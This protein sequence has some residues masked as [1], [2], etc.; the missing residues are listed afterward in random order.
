MP[1][2]SVAPRCKRRTAAEAMASHALDF[3]RP[4]T[5]TKEREHQQPPLLARLLSSSD[6]LRSRQ[7]IAL[8]QNEGPHHQKQQCLLSTA[9]ILSALN[10]SAMQS[11]RRD[12]KP[13]HQ[14]NAYT[15]TSYWMK[16]PMEI[17]IYILYC[18][19][20]QPRQHTYYISDKL[21]LSKRYC[22]STTS[23]AIIVILP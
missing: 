22:H 11:I 9:F 8:A 14:P 13:S 15:T 2:C 10:Q 16:P 6:P 12:R 1:D 23:D 18:Y 19:P 7:I 17:F 4:W 20:R 5:M 21:L 3:T